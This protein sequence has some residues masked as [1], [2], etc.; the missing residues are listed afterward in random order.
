VNDQICA[1]NGV[2]VST[3]AGEAGEAEYR[4]AL[5]AYRHALGRASERVLVANRQGARA[6]RTAT[7]MPAL[8]TD[9]PE[10]RSAFIPERTSAVDRAGAAL[11][12]ATGIQRDIGAF[13]QLTPELA[14]EAA[15]RADRAGEVPLRGVPVAVK[16]LIDL[17][18]V[19]TR[20]GTPG[21]GHRIPR[22][23][24]A[25]VSSLLRAGAVPLGKSQTHELGLG[26]ITPH[27]RNPFDRE[28]IAGGSSG[29]SA[30]AVAAGLVGGALGTDTAGSIRCPA[31]LCG[32]V[33][34]KPTRGALPTAGVA[35]LSATQDTVGVLASTVSDCALMFRAAGGP[36]PRGWRSAQSLCVG[37]NR[38]L[39]STRVAPDV[40]DAVLFACDELRRAGVRVVDVAL[41]DS[42]LAGASSMVVVLYEAAQR[43]GALSAAWPEGFGPQVRAALRGGGE[44]RRE[45]YA[46]ALQ[47]QL[48]L[49][50]EVDAAMAEAEVDA[51]VTPTVP[52]AAVPCGVQRVVLGEREEA[53]EAVHAR[54]T[55]LASV[56]GLPALSVPCGLGSQGLPVGLQ[57]VGRA[58]REEDLFALGVVVEQGQGAQLVAQ[59]RSHIAAGTVTNIRPRSDI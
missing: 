34:L 49:R 44:V 6:L 2:T 24:A 26:M 27:T 4:A 37:L 42:A 11:A 14:I 20:L 35:V 55:V 25:V 31:A 32:V 21:A 46:A 1:D 45:A 38:A 33:G 15:R 9:V 29:G 22:R 39:C 56:T 48:R 19:P 23:S 5:A 51:L 17:A 3:G 53:I 28:R 30:A 18:G 41:P 12:A 7:P 52:I 16:D 58:G 59:A 8:G 50:G 13:A 47:I 36:P 10:R 43:W 57:L 40:R 54:L